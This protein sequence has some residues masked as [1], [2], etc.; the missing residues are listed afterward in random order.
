MKISPTENT[1]LHQ[2]LFENWENYD[3]WAPYFYEEF[4][5]PQSL[6]LGRLAGVMTPNMINIADELKETFTE[7]VF[8][9]LGEEKKSV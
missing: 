4:I 8:T 3:R 9:K 7:W 1:E 6:R 2:L 5:K